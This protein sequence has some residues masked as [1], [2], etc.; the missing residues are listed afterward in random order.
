M[1]LDQQFP[2]GIITVET[3]NVR[4][5]GAEFLQELVE[6]ELEAIGGTVLQTALVSPK[7][8]QIVEQLA[9]MSDRLNPACIF[10]LGGTGLHAQDVTPDATQQVLHRPAPGIAELLRAHVGQSNPEFA[11]TRGISGVR[12]W[13]LVINL[14]EK[15]DELVLCFEKLSSILPAAVRQLGRFDRLVSH[16][17]LRLL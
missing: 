7:L 16:Q 17:Q 13:T 12:G 1:T 4:R 11:L 15:P 5:I 3:D 10:T 9:L 2:V 14:P 6:R 8:D